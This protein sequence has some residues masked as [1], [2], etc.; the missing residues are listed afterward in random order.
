MILQNSFFQTFYPNLSIF[1]KWIYLS[2]PS[3]FATLRFSLVF[4]KFHSC[5][6]YLDID[7]R[8]LSILTRTSFCL[9]N[10]TS[11]QQLRLQ[12]E[13][14]MAD[15]PGKKKFSQNSQNAQN[16]TL[17]YWLILEILLVFITKQL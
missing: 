1:L 6:F 10:L 9:Q 2:Y 8:L 3:Y 12:A 13:V 11:C 17:Y 5:W 15:N 14:L 4:R 16:S 7:F